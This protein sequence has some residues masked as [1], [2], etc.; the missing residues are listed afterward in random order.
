MRN[1]CF[2]GRNSVSTQQGG[3]S[4]WRLAIAA[5]D[6]VYDQ[7]MNELRKRRTDLMARPSFQRVL[8]MFDPRPNRD[9]PARRR[10]ERRVEHLVRD[11]DPDR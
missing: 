4:S 8:F 10:Q 11:G 6:D 9:C 5:A 3:W 2:Q 7:Y 1:N